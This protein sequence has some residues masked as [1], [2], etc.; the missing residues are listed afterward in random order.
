MLQQTGGLNSAQ[1]VFVGSGGTLQVSGGTLQVS[2][3][4]QDWGLLDCGGGTGT[5]SVS[6][7]SI[8]DLTGS[9]ANAAS[10][11][12][13]V[14]PNS[15]VIVPAGFNPSQYFLTY[16][17]SGITHTAGT[18]LTVAAGQTILGWGTIGDSV[19]CQGTIGDGRGTIYLSGGLALAG[20]GNVNL[21]SGALLTDSASSTMSG[22]QLT[23]SNEYVGYYGAGG[24]AQSAGMNQISN[25]L[26]LG[27]NAGSSGTYTLTG[28]GQ[29][30]A[31]WDNGECVGCSGTGTFTQS[32]GTNAISYD[33][34]LGYNSGSSGTYSLSGSGQLSV[35]I[36]EVVGYSGTGTFTQSGGTNTIRNTAS[37]IFGLY[38]AYNPGSR[39]TYNLDG[40]VLLTPG[41]VSGG[42]AAA[43]NF[44]GGTLHADSS[45]STTVPMTLTGSGGNA[46]VDT[47]GYTVTLSGLLSGPG[48][49]T[50]TDS[51][52][53]ILGSPNTYGGGTTVTGGTLSITNPS[54]LGSGGLT[55]GPHGVFNIDAQNCVFSSL[56]GSAGGVLTDLSTAATGVT[57]L[58]V[59]SPP[60][61]S[62]NY[63]GTIC[64]GSSRTLALVVSGSGM[65][66][67]SGTSTY[68]GGTTVSGG[69]L[70][71]S[72]PESMPSTGIL[73]IQSGG[74]VVLGVLLGDPGGDSEPAAADVA[75]DGASNSNT[76]TR[77][78]QRRQRYRSAADTD[79]G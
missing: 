78:H 55:I 64:D 6:S 29:L 42:G 8:V 51:G 50:K 38:L 24:F 63:G 10:T 1:L 61:S 69:T 44:G 47:A 45:F 71:F 13:S 28:L 18:P 49:L 43:F 32:G 30:S 75:G 36:Y 76:N 16:S 12:L 39:G 60:S 26:Y 48:G 37:S 74:E 52:T 4:L 67:L 79:S 77:G 34:W 9:V 59:C 58:T 23:T 15:L 62:S 65:L 53:L 46:T 35:S 68:S 66:T 11:S 20:T 72:T 2:G 57:T 73:D 41:L 33:L 22:G 56:S 54:A 17:N 7:S 5:I 40:G 31:W 14:G 3:G 27:Y 25:G 70:D 19:N 21:G